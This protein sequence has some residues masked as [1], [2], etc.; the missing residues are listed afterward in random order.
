MKSKTTNE[1]DRQLDREP[2]P[3]PTVAP[4]RTVVS[5]EADEIARLKTAIEKRTGQP[6]RECHVRFLHRGGVRA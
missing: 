6:L 2:A 4:L 1:S 3:D 5:V